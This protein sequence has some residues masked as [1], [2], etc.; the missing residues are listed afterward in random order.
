[1]TPVTVV[2]ATLG[3]A[4]AK[5]ILAV[6]ECPDRRAFHTVTRIG[7]VTG[8]D[9]AIRGL[10]DQLL[11]EKTLAGVDTVRNTLFPAALAAE[12]PDPTRLADRYLRLLPYLRQLDPNNR[13]GTYF[14]RIVAYPAPSGALNQLPEL[15]RRLTVEQATPA[16][17]SARYE[18]NIDTPTVA[19]PTVEPG[20]DTSAMAFPCLSLLSFQ[21]DDGTLHTLAQYRSQ[22]LLQRGYGNYLAIA[23]L[24]RYV[25]AAAGLTTGQ[26][27]VVA[28]LAA[29]DRTGKA[30]VRRIQAVL[31]GAD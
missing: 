3:R 14:S 11:E 30:D 18:V 1:V 29:A 4:W 13:R 21:L 6:A 12:E 15:V 22:Y 28:G 9:A 25:A 16:P 8:E 17:K 5:T 31:D 2:E 24:M 19:V 10:V 27:T 7:D 26:L 23:G 20:R